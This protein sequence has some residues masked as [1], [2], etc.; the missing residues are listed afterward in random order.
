MT[1]PVTWF[2]TDVLAGAGIN[3]L[4]KEL[5]LAPVITDDNLVSVPLYYPNFWGVVTADP[6]TKSLKLK[7]TKKYG[8]DKISF[9]KIYN[10]R[11]QCGMCYDWV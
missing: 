10:S 5:R 2:S 11:H 9:T 7:I 3:V 6:Q 4:Q 1:A 8:K